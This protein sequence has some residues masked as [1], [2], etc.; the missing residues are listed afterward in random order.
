MKFVSLRWKAGIFISIIL[1]LLTTSWTWINI[2][3]QLVIFQNNISNNFI[4]VTKVLNQLITNEA[5]QLSSFSQLIIKQYVDESKENAL[6]EKNILNDQWLFLNINLDIDF[7]GIY[8]EAGILVEEA[9]SDSFVKDA[10][11]K[12]ILDNAVT[13]KPITNSHHLHCD[14]NC[15]LIV[16]EPYIT[17]NGQDGVIVIA[18]NI[19]GL[20]RLFSITTNSDLAILLN[21]E[22][23]PSIALTDERLINNGKH[24]IWAISNAHTNLG[25]LKASSRTA[26]FY[27]QN[28]LDTFSYNNSIYFIKKI[29][30]SVSESKN[31]AT[32]INIHDYSTE[33]KNLE[34]NII[35]GLIFGI[36]GLFITGVIFIL[37]TSHFI[38]RVLNISDTLFLL[39]KQEFIKAKEQLNLKN[40]STTDELSLLESSTYQV[41]GDLEHLNHEILDKNALLQGK[42]GELDKS[43]AFLDRIFNNSQIF[44]TT[45]NRDHKI[46]K[47]NQKFVDEFGS[48]HQSFSQLIPLE[49]DLMSFKDNTALLFSK[50][51]NT[52]QHQTF[53]TN[54][55]D[56]RL[57]IAWAHSIETDEFGNEVILSIGMDQTIEKKA[58]D[59]LRWIAN[60][61]TLTGI[62]NRRA[63]NNHLQSLLKNN[64]SGALIFIDVNRFKQINDIYGHNAGDNVLINIAHTL[65]DNFGNT[66]IPCRFSGDEFT[67]IC[68]EIKK[69]DLPSILDNMA[70]VLNSHIELQGGGVLSYSVSIGA[71]F[72]NQ[73][74]HDIE[75]LIINADMAMYHAKEKG[76]GYWHIF[77]PSDPRAE[78]LKRDNRTIVSVRKALKNQLFYLEYQPILNIENNVISHY[79]ALIRI[80]DEEIEPISPGIFIPLAEKTGEI[81]DIDKWVINQA[82]SDLNTLLKSNISTKIAINIS[83]PT[84]QS[85]TF[86]SLITEALSRHSISSHSLIIELTETSYIEN[87]Q[88]V[89]YNLKKITS[90]GVTVAL[91]DFGVG[92]SSFTYLKQL[93]L[94]YVK[95]DGSYIRDLVSHKS[96]QV[97]VKSL[98]SMTEAFGMKTIA[99]FV[100]NQETLDLLQ[101]LGVTHGQGFHIGKPKPLNEYLKNNVY[102]HQLKS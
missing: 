91:D 9:F 84:L 93:P 20:V 45:Q 99:E 83:A 24:Y 50:R 6:A 85:D 10:H 4:H 30:N 95:L 25:I 26:P 61:D 54:N 76:L 74:N 86:T 44:S 15:H 68:P 21:T 96:D 82:L 88:Q 97:F 11:L 17:N 55:N 87:F 52:F 80:N 32:F 67:V 43:R 8:D 98:A 39:P 12:D 48:K 72:F 94:S 60:H 46:I 13:Q 81:R 19:A 64:K 56:K 53:T 2:N 23:K 42:I 31:Q 62:S 28:N 49:R 59:D 75:A 58:E 16:F 101:T 5:L 51:I 3:K 40:R 27:I 14:N 36:I 77:D 65:R 35:L 33:Q 41:I 71:A 29:E 90:F 63:F 66:T 79:E 100:E 73:E 102:T 18:K 37:I 78:Q 69:E 34:N 1:I 92:F 7:I 47:S 70:T 57:F 38:K 22:G 89:L